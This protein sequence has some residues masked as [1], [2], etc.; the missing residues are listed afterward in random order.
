[1]IKRFLSRI[2]TNTILPKVLRYSFSVFLF[3]IPF[4]WFKNGLM[5]LGGDSSRLYFYDPLHYLLNHTLSSISPSGIGVESIGFYGLPFVATLFVLKSVIGSPSLLVA[6]FQGMNF[7]VGFLSC[8]GIIKNLLPK[9]VKS[10]TF[11]IEYAS[12]ISGLFYIFSPVAI[13]GWDKPM[14]VHSQVFLNPLLFFLLLKYVIS[15]NIKFLLSSLLITFIFSPSFSVDSAPALFSFYPVSLIFL[16]FYRILIIKKHIILKHIFLALVLFL[17]LQSFHLIPQ[18][19]NIFSPGSAFNSAIF[20]KTGQVDRGQSYFLS[21][22]TSVKVTLNILGRVQAP[23]T[24]KFPWVYFIFP[25]VILL[26]LLKNKSKTFILLIGAFLFTFFWA[27]AHITTVGFNFYVFL[28]NFPGFAM[29]RNFFGQF[30]YTLLFFY[31]LVFGYAIY[32]VFLLLRERY[33]YPILVSL[34]IL[35]VYTGWPLITASIVNKVLSQSDVHIFAAMDPEYENF[36]SFLRS[37][38]I[39]GKIVSFPLTDP[40]YQILAGKNGGAYQGP[41]TI[42]YLTGKKDFAGYEEFNLFKD[43]LMNA[44]KSNDTQAIINIFSLLNISYLFHNEDPSIYDTAFPGFPYQ[45]VR[46]Y[47]PDTQNAYTS[48]I[49]QLPFKEIY[50]KQNYS[51]YTMNS[52]TYLPHIYIPKQKIALGLSAQNWDLALHFYNISTNRIELVSPQNVREPMDIFKADPIDIYR[53]IEKDFPIPAQYPYVKWSFTHPLYPLMV[54]RERYQLNKFKSND[55]SY[56]DQLLVT[57]AK[58]IAEMK[59]WGQ[60]LILD[61]NISSTSQLLSLWREPSGLSLLTTRHYNHWEVSLSRY[62]QA[63]QTAVDT[64]DNSSMNST[65]KDEKRIH[66]REELKYDYNALN[67]SITY[68]TTL[69]TSDKQYLFHTIDDMYDTFDKQLVTVSYTPNYVTYD[70]QPFSNG[71]FIP[72]VQKNVATTSAIL[73][74]DVIATKINKGEDQLFDQY[75]PLQIKTDQV[76]RISLAVESIKYP[77]IPDVWQPIDKLST[78]AADEDFI[79]A[80]IPWDREIKTGYYKE[81]TGL[82]E[83]KTYLLSFHYNTFGKSVKTGLLLEK[84]N[85][86]KS[87]IHAIPIFSQLKNVRRDTVFNAV[88]NTDNSEKVL[89]VLQ[90]LDDSFDLKNISIDNFSMIQL[91]AQPDILFKSTQAKEIIQKDIPKITFTKI[92]PIAYQVQVHNATTPYDLVLSD[93]YNANWKVYRLDNSVFNEPTIA[94]YFTGDIEE[95]ISPNSLFGKHTFAT[96]L[97]KALPESQHYMVNG[98]AN[99]WTI[100]P[101]DVGGEK[102][103]TLVIEMN[104]QRY[105]YLGTLVSTV[106]FIIIILLLVIKM[107]KNNIRYSKA[108][109]HSR[110]SFYY[111]S[112]AAHLA[113][114]KTVLDVGCGEN[115]PLGSVPKKFYAEGVDIFTESL[116]RSESHNIHDAYKNSDIRKI[117]QLYKEKSFDAVI[118]LDVIEHFDKDEAKALIKDMEAIAKKKVILLTPNGFYKQDEIG[119]NPY[120][121]HLSG[122]STQDLKDLG[123]KLFCLRGLKY[124][125]GD[126]ATIK[127]KPWVFWGFISFISEPLLYRF[128]QLS[129]HLFAVKEFKHEKNS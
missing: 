59:Q 9:N 60:S 8:Y 1:M 81:I 37:L 13:D 82:E 74:N 121:V 104:T 25:I 64:V 88:I 94:R 55:D 38:Q 12:I 54:W 20:T 73:Y 15:S 4:F 26:G 93:A 65:W 108:I 43:P 70:L 129:Y 56:T 27:S 80:A 128:P 113:G 47:L 53:S 34:L 2:A 105:F 63:I 95:T 30:E 18:L 77:T 76:N 36:L 107:A 62:T 110:D 19:I 89:F 40:G 50:H 10:P 115:S 28:F 84:Y 86:D 61:K 14:L 97:K 112:L 98:Y 23:P 126:Y 90:G 114:C 17:G 29:F 116:K 46:S 123:Y 21:V 111:K 101:S 87:K 41:S 52:S 31:A 48:Y 103:Y 67:S 75:Q 72:F 22:A 6:G 35:F 24:D 44:F 39:D 16:G 127:L 100:N 69:S 58:R 102:D 71:S 99:G 118:S 124:L 85:G 96:L 57:A 5:D 79:P 7:V 106:T 117:K 49:S 119:G 42:A 109:L 120:Q 122:W 91:P 51:I 3:I 83:N 11:L 125:K 45:H 33:I 92:S 78:F 68:N 32:N 66:I